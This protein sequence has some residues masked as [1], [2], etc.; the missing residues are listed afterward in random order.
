MRSLHAFAYVGEGEGW[1][2]NSPILSTLDLLRPG[3]DVCARGW[4]CIYGFALEAC[5]KKRLPSLLLAPSSKQRRTPASQNY[6]YDH[7]G[8]C[9]CAKIV[10]SKSRLPRWGVALLCVAAVLA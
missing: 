2:G 8:V 5:V 1:L 7:T 6:Y 4:M 9:L 10:R 3:K